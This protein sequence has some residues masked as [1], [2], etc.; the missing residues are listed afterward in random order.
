MRISSFAASAPLAHVLNV[1]WNLAEF[2]A[3][4]ALPTTVLKPSRPFWLS[5]K[6]EYRPVAMPHTPLNESFRYPACSTT[7]FIDATI[8][9][10]DRVLST[11]SAN[12]E[13]MSL[14]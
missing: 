12:F 9:P 4:S 10:V 7:C 14:K 5:A 2:T 3:R 1:V 6:A 13:V 11:Q 8:S